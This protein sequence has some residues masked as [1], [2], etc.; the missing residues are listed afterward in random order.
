MRST[1]N[2]PELEKEYAAL[3]MNSLCDWLPRVHLLACVDS[4]RVQKSGT[5]CLYLG[6]R[7]ESV[8]SA[9]D[10]E[11]FVIIW[12]N[13]L[14]SSFCAKRII[15]DIGKEMDDNHHIKSTMNVIWKVV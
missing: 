10:S 2:M 14:S 6:N 5:I 8:K 11:K 1:A 15:N 4:C 12:Y 3:L 13:F 9:Y 7:I